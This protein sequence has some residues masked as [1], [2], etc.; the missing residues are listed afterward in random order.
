M[1]V[2][3]SGGR[4]AG[5]LWY[6]YCMVRTAA[7]SHARFTTKG[8]RYGN[9]PQYNVQRAQAVFGHVGCRCRH[10]GQHTASSTPTIQT[11]QQH[12]RV[13]HESRKCPNHCFQ[14][15]PQQRAIHKVGTPCFGKQ[16]RWAVS[17]DGH[18]RPN[19]AGYEIS[20]FQSTHFAKLRRGKRL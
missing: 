3:D 19:S 13:S 8:P 1:T 9:N 5:I 15:Q 14:Q 12:D 16:R 10:S 7:C 20:R 11:K 18:L 6:H 2:S 17:S 4:L